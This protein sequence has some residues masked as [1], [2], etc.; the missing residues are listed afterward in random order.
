MGRKILV[1]CG[2]V[3]AVLNRRPQ[4]MRSF[5][6][7]DSNIALICPSDS[8]TYMDQVREIGF[9]VK[10][11]DNNKQSLNPFA[12][13][14]YFQKLKQAIA[15]I[16][17]DDVFVFH[18]KPIIH[19]AR[20][21]RQL[22]IRCHVLFAGLGFVFSNDRSFKRWLTQKVVSQTLKNSLRAANTVFFQNPDDRATL[23]GLSLIHI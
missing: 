7:L 17:P 11:I 12:D 21:C 3:T 16:A 23:D 10:V 19:T 15:D 18:L 22:G 4:L 5:A 1:I 14:L 13:L 2:D 8:E 6:E 9:D 20:A